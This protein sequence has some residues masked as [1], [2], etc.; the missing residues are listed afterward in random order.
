M[1]V[2]CTGADAACAADCL[3]TAL[4]VLGPIAGLELANRLPDVEALFLEPTPSGLRRHATAG[5][6]ARL[7]EADRFTPTTTQDPK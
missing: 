5:I 6:R 4:Y 2:L 1:T 7:R 3:S